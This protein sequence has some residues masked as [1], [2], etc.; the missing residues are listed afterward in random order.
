MKK[1]IL[2]VIVLVLFPI[3]SWA[4]VRWEKKDNFYYLTKN[5]RESFSLVG[6]GANK[7]SS[8]YLKYDGID[9]LVRGADDWK[10]YGRLNL[11]GNNLFSLPVRPGTKVDEIHF[12][13]GG[14]FGNS[15]Q[16]DSLMRLYGD[17]YFYAVLTAIF[18]YQDGVYKSLSV[19][20]FWDWFH[21][22][23]GAW[24]KDGARIKTLGKNPVRKDCSIYH[25]SFINPRVSEP[26]KDILIS[27]SWIDD[28]PYSEI[29]AVTIK[30]PDALEANPREDKEFKAPARDESKE[31][32]DKRVEW[33]FDKDI[34]GWAGGCSDNWD[35]EAFWQADSFGR[36]G[37]MV[38]PA[39]NW[40][41]D[42]FSW[43]EKKIA[44]PDQENLGLQFLRH[45]ALYSELNKQW[46]D[47]LLKVIVQGPTASDTVYD[48]I[49]SGEWSLET[50]DLSHYKG[51]VVTIRFENHG[52]GNVQLGQSSSPACDGEDAI[53]DE[54]RL[55]QINK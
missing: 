2:S 14:N 15:Y 50:V 32:A 29:F 51:K 53:I 21:M 42:K 12:L 7:F 23:P 24:S 31:T 27:D 49:Y 16:H 46:S 37:V 13:A 39:C 6:A 48:K 35:A 41:G 54:I 18:I 11:E 43:I 44:L 20:V 3:V 33:P 55:I 8:K 38:I 25:I 28:L 17:K 40:A 22:G 45:S 19:P 36:K 30:S 34:D 4:G 5:T 52:A 26:V 47:G 9:F 10:D 1:K